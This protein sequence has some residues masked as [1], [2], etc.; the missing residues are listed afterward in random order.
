M[1]VRVGVGG[2]VMVSVWVCDV[3]GHCVNVMVA[4]GVGGGVSEREAVIVNVGSSEKLSE[5]VHVSVCGLVREMGMEGVAV[6]VQVNDGVRVCV[7]VGMSVSVSD[8]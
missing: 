8:G 3:V 7:L 1:N 4:E 6:S 2:G 5:M